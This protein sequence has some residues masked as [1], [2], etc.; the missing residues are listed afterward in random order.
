MYQ[1]EICA[2]LGYNAPYSINSL[3]TFRHELSVQSSIEILAWKL[4]GCVVPK[5]R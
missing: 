3:P 5:R 4:Y 2:L 1:D